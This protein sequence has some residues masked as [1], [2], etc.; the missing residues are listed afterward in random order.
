MTSFRT[1]DDLGEI[2]GKRVLVRQDLN[3]PL[4]EGKVTDD[5]RLR[6]AVP[7]VTELADRGAIVL[8]LAH[9]GRPKVPGPEHSTALVTKPFEAVLGRPVRYIDWEAD[10]AALAGDIERLRSLR[11]LYRHPPGLRRRLMLAA[12]R[13]PGPV[14]RQ[15]VRAFR[16]LRA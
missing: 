2:R 11:R 6:A 8:V 7:T 10:H 16:L 4:I 14:A 3:V 9:I 15:A 12:A 5:T 1:L 13:L